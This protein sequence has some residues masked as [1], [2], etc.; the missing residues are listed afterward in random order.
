MVYK[1]NKLAGPIELLMHTH[2]Y[3]TPTYKF[4]CNA[5]W[6]I[7]GCDIILRIQ[8]YRSIAYRTYLA[9]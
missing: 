6:K 7:E 4:L 9:H 8:G 3:P 1:E 5:T 2:L